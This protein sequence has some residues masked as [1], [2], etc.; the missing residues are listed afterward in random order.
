MWKRLLPLSLVLVFCP[1]L[2][3]AE[4]D[5][6]EW[7][8]VTAPAFRA[9]LAPLI[10]HRRTEGMK[11][12]VIETTDALNAQQLKA[13]DAKPLCDHVQGLCAKAKGKCYVLLV[14][15]VKANAVRT[16]VPPLRGAA[17]R[18]KGQPTDNG[19]GRPDKDL[20]PRVAVGRLP[21]RTEEEARQMVARTLAFERDRSPGA[22]RNRVTLLVG[23]PGGSS[24][25]E[26]RFAEYFVES[27]AGGR[28]QRVPPEWTGRAVF[29]AA[30]S[31]YAVPDDALRDVSLR[32]LKEGQM[33]SIYM[34]HSGAFGFWSGGTP[35]VDRK[36]WEKVKLPHSG[37]FFSCGCFGCQLTGGDEGYG[38]A[39]IRNPAGPVAVL[40]SH[41]ES[42]SAFG[43]F[44][45]DGMLECLSRP[46]APDRVADYWLAVTANMARG[47]MDGFTFWLYDNADGSRGKIPL[48]VQRKE[49]LEMWM[50]LGDP[51]VRLPLRRPT[52]RLEAAGTAS[53]GATVKVTG[54][55]P[56]AL[57]AGPVRLTLERPLGSRTPGLE[58]V[59]KDAAKVKAVLLANHEKANNVVLKSCEVQPRDGKFEGTFELPAQLP[60]P[61]LTV[62][63]VAAN[64]SESALGVLTL[65]V[66]KKATGSK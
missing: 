56:A 27:L 31:P 62:R 53:P 29:H 22:W 59:P 34:G 35:F 32:Y 33:I 19:Y 63:A 39:A 46:E 24:A 4:K 55:L 58:P 1:P 54:S 44:A 61:R 11:V 20:M 66:A 16:V 14:G 47:K 6:P 40:G 30:G 38:L 50:L 12:H 28:L 64:E 48:E 3:A 17:G 18:M 60:W 8:V 21:A 7:I 5:A 42:Y 43:Q 49:H 45:I 51:A 25:A 10:E 26:K 2:V 57:A 36:D 65:P 41:G 23:N 37:V 13:G 52:I 9:A 15:A